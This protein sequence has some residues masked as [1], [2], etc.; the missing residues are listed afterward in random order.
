VQGAGFRDQPLALT[1]SLGYAVMLYTE[2]GW[3]AA[4]YTERKVA[5]SSEATAA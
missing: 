5:I 4:L 1:Y 2:P 3:N